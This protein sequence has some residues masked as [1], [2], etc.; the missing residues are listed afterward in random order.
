V[1]S[2]RNETE[3]F[4]L[5]PE[6][7]GNLG[8]ETIMDASVHPPDVKHLD[9]CFDTWPR[10]CIQE[11]FPCFIVTTELQKEL[12]QRA[13]SGINFQDLTVSKSD[14]FHDLNASDPALPEFVRLNVTG[15]KG[16]DDFWLAE[17][18]YLVVSSRVL[19]VL[20]KHGLT[21]AEVKSLSVH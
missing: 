14:V 19:D 10:D 6:V 2:P 16:I 5:E 12:L 18:G 20:K 9:Y 4:I 21:L 13:F 1:T 8:D 15:K 17:H 3:Y 7:S 11:V